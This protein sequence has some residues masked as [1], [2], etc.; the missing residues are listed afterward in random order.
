MVDGQVTGRVDAGGPVVSVVSSKGGV[1]RTMVS[2][3]LA[4]AMSHS[5]SVLLVDGDTFCGDVE[6]SLG[7]RPVYRMD[8]LVL[9]LSADP[10]LDI[11]AMLA[12]HGEN[13]S[14]LC[15]PKNPFM[16]DQMESRATWN[17]VERAID[18]AG[19]VVF[20]TG[21]GMSPLTLSS[22]DVAT[23]I[24]LLSGTDTASVNA[25]R[26]MLGVMDQLSMD[27]TR[28]CLVVNR[29]TT[30]IG[31]HLDD[32]IEVLGMEPA[33]V[34]PEDPTVAMSMNRGVPVVEMAPHSP[35][36][37]VLIAL[38]ASINQRSARDTSP[39]IEGAP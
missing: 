39:A 9:Q 34:I 33:C 25:A 23:R 26:T 8:D 1:G 2:S 15:A 37:R 24:I 19:S 16:A 11:T 7:L 3:N 4:A 27:R 12:R 21:A 10:N 14:V 20:D 31:L 36:A 35:A 29:P 38:A 6:F 5:T 13:L 18:P 30:K 17:V 28:V 22:M 32:V